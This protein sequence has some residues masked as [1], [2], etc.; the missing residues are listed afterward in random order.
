MSF[1]LR[2]NSEERD[3]FARDRRDHA[4]QT[5]DDW[6]LNRR[7]PR[8][9]DEREKNGKSKMPQPRFAADRPKNDKRDGGNSDRVQPI[10]WPP[11]RVSN[12]KKPNRKKQ[13]ERDD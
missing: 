13:N 6:F 12:F 3:D 8:N 1:K 10:K 7:N 4:H 2:R 11:I 5:L 9:P